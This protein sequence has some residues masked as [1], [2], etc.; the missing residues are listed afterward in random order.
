VKVPPQLP[1]PRLRTAALVP[2][3]EQY[4]GRPMTPEGR[5]HCWGERDAACIARPLFVRRVLSGT[6]LRLWFGARNWEIFLQHESA[7]HSTW[8]KGHATTQSCRGCIGNECYLNIRRSELNRL[9]QAAAFE[10]LIHPYR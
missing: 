2:A 8:S 1:S 4:V 10:L 6:E 7:A 3:L 5:Q 9:R